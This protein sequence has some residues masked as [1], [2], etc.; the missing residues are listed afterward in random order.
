MVILVL[1]NEKCLKFRAFIFEFQGSAKQSEREESLKLTLLLLFE[2]LKEQEGFT[3]NA[4]EI[5]EFAELYSNEGYRVHW[6]SYS[7]E[8][9]DR[10]S[11]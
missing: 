6:I 2:N 7:M 3:V 5:E 8:D 11:R 10:Q 4:S 1:H 9:D